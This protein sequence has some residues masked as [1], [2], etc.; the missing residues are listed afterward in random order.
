LVRLFGSTVDPLPPVTGVANALILANSG[1]SPQ[2]ESVYSHAAAFGRR[3][4]EQGYV[5]NHPSF[6]TTDKALIP[7]GLSIITLGDRP[8][9]GLKCHPEDRL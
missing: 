8:Q 2:W 4:H 6:K 3:S 5:R 1:W 7:V 9:R